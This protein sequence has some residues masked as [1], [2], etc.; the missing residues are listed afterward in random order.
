MISIFNA[1]LG[2]EIGNENTQTS[3]LNFT[4]KI[5]KRKHFQDQQITFI[6]H[7]Y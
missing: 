4:P 5:D 7:L 3:T 2:L 6:F 1:E